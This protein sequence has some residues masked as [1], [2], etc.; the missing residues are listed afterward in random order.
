MR[1]SVCVLLTLAVVLVGG[2]RTFAA[3][4][5]WSV[6]DGG[7]DHWYDVIPSPST[8]WEQ[9]R[10]LAESSSYLGMPGYL[11]TLTTESENAWVTQNLLRPSPNVAL[12]IGGF[13]PPGSP[14]PA[15]GWQWVTGEPWGYTNW[16]GAPP[17]QEPNNLGGEDRLNI[18]GGGWGPRWWTG[19]DRCGT[20][21]DVLADYP[22]MDA[23]VVEYSS[24]VPEPSALFVW[25]GLGAMGLIAAWRR[26]KRAAA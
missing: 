11:A 24:T 17:T 3:P 10:V 6:S 23:C 15:G 9:F 14:E 1:R 21:N 22:N 16:V 25:S 5:Q 12:A 13:Q 26:L 20:W 19:E 8:T 18:W 4:M 7:N 2:S